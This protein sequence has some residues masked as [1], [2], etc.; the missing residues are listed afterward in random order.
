M[1]ES[2]QNRQ[3]N[4]ECDEENCGRP[5]EMC[6]NR[7][8]ASLPGAVEYSVKFSIVDT[9]N[10]GWGVCSKSDILPGEL[11]MEYTG[12]VTVNRREVRS[13]FRRQFPSS[14]WRSD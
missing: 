1:K 6:S 8:F 14:C 5:Q 4:Y 13:S 9:A 2:C 3:M 10:R 7:A 12:I 11:I